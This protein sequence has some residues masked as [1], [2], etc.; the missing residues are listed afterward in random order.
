[1]TGLNAAFGM[2]NSATETDHWNVEDIGD[3]VVFFFFF[4]LATAA[5]ICLCQGIWK[6]KWL[7]TLYNVADA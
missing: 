7:E 2:S 3:I 1:M 5:H 6:R 4:F